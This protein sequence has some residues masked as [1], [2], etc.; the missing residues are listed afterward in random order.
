[1]ALV[2]PWRSLKFGPRATALAA[3]LSS[4]LNTVLTS[5]LFNV[6]ISDQLTSNHTLVDDFASDKAIITN[7]S[8]PDLASTHIQN[9]INHL[10][11]WYKTW[12]V[13]I[14]KSKSI[15]GTFTLRQ[16]ICKSLYFNNQPLPPAL[17]GILVS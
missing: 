16:E 8:N 9:H 17:C 6:F 5:L 4:G 7:N 11:T 14:N 3:P 15:H 10:Y 1:M 12:G 13:K 2:G